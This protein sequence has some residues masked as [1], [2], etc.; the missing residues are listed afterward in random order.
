MARRTP[1]TEPCAAIQGRRTSSSRTASSFWSLPPEGRMANPLR[2]GGRA[3][4][5]KP[6]PARERNPELTLEDIRQLGGAEAPPPP[7][8][9][10]APSPTGHLHIG[11]AR[12]ALVNY[13]AAKKQGGQF[14]LRVEDTD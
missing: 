3:K 12:T 5:V 11:G 7:R 10:F 9:R 6:E 8:F 1:G 2:I 4:R 13:L 14:V